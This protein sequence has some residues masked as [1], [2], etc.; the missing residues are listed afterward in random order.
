MEMEKRVIQFAADYINRINLGVSINLEIISLYRKVYELVTERFPDKK[1]S[2]ALDGLFELSLKIQ[3]CMY[4]H[5][6]PD[7]LLENVLIPRVINVTSEIDKRTSKSYKKHLDKLMKD[8]KE[9]ENPIKTKEIYLEIYLILTFLIIYSVEEL[10]MNRIEKDPEIKA[11]E[12]IQTQ[13]EMVE[14]FKYFAG[15]IVEFVAIELLEELKLLNIVK[16]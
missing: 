1:H 9:S 3:G 5:P 2:E 7:R 6:E 11:N 8:L 4:G 16:Y 10:F 14:K 15:E 12:E 13:L